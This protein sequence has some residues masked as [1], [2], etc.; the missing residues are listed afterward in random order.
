MSLLAL[1]LAVWALVTLEGWTWERMLPG[2]SSGGPCAR[3]QGPRS[4]RSGRR[5]ASGDQ[6]VSPIAA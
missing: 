2:R 5:P 6:Q 1:V 4:R 3:T